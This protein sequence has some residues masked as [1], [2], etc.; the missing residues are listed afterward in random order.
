MGNQDSSSG[1]VVEV[2]VILH[3]PHR[4]SADAAIRDHP[5]VFEKDTMSFRHPLQF[6]VIHPFWAGYVDLSRL[7][8]PEPSTFINAPFHVQGSLEVS[9]EDEAHIHYRGDL[10]RGET[11]SGI[12][13]V[14][15]LL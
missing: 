15:A 11:G 14:R 5:S 9:L 13:F 12:G 1:K 3:D 2:V 4:P 10:F 6:G 8:Y 7:K